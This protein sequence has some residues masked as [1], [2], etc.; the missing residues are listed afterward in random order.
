M[1]KALKYPFFKAVFSTSP[2][3]GDK[4]VFFP[5]LVKLFSALPDPVL[6]NGGQVCPL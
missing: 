2:T 5:P 4:E 3:A 1:K 6:E